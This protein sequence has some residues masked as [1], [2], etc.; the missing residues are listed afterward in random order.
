MEQPVQMTLNPHPMTNIN[1]IA[2]RDTMAITVRRK[3]TFAKFFNS[4][5]KEG[6]LVSQFTQLR[7]TNATA[8]LGMKANIATSTTTIASQALV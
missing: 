7:A 1:V 4:H 2:H 5:A 6:P 3:R 8:Y